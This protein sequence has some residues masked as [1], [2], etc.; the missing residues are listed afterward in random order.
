MLGEVFLSLVIYIIINLIYRSEVKNKMNF[1][2][3][4]IILVVVLYSVYFIIL[5]QNTIIKTTS[6]EYYLSSSDFDENSLMFISASLEFG[7]PASFLM[8]M[9]IEETSFGTKGVAVTNNNWFGTG[10]TIYPTPSSHKGRFELYPNVQ[11]SVR[12]A[13]RLLGKPNSYYRVT[14]II[15]SNGGLEQSYVAIAQSI[16]SKWCVDE[17]GKPCTYD[18]K[19]LLDDIEKFNLKSVYFLSLF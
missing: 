1:I 5:S 9:A 16:T 12:D 11:E 15:I 4:L 19:K 13:A 3:K 14:N 7:V 17:E 6:N 2:K 10:L 8:A 18:A